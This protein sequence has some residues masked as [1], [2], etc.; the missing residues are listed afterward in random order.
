MFCLCENCDEGIKKSIVEPEHGELTIPFLFSDDVEDDDYDI[1]VSGGNGP[2]AR[3]M[4]D[5]AKAEVRFRVKKFV[6][7]LMRTKDGDGS[8]YRQELTKRM[9]EKTEIVVMKNSPSRGT[10]SNKASRIKTNANNGESKRASIGPAR[11][12]DVTVHV[13]DID[14]DK[15]KVERYRF[16]SK[17]T[18]LFTDSVDS[19]KESATAG[20][21]EQGWK[22]T[23]FP[24]VV[25][26]GP[27]R[28]DGMPRQI[29]VLGSHKRFKRGTYL[30]SRRTFGKCLSTLEGNTLRVS[31]LDAADA[32]EA[33]KEAAAEEERAYREKED[34][35]ARRRE[36]RRKRKLQKK[37]SRGHED[38][39][40]EAGV[41]ARIKR[42][43]TGS[44]VSKTSASATLYRWDT[45][46]LDE[47]VSDEALSKSTSRDECDLRIEVIDDEDDGEGVGIETLQLE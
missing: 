37:S 29:A 1:K 34:A 42:V 28:F 35:R 36:E 23:M 32:L 39:R 15:V 44:D 38:A 4:R 14:E 24:S 21:V 11:N 16:F 20:I 30:P 33:A 26:V 8:I 13:S 6:R 46:V 9:Q 47:D 7:K 22:C 45:S 3:L 10:V 27:M 19:V 25:L 17:R 40:P 2:A 12:V 41:S 18:F 5:K 31:P 43:P